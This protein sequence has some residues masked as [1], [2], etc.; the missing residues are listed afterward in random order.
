MIYNQRRRSTVSVSVTYVNKMEI[1]AYFIIV[2]TTITF[3]SVNAQTAT[4][5]SL[6]LTPNTGMAMNYWWGLVLPN[7]CTGPGSPGI[8]VKSDAYSSRR[9]DK[10]ICRYW[11]LFKYQQ[12]VNFIAL[13]SNMM[14]KARLATVSKMSSCTVSEL[15]QFQTVS[16]DLENIWF[17]RPT[18]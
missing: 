11:P 7:S 12:T 3:V 4:C 14:G 8:L 16:T 18:N 9:T 1:L 17:H 15:F 6:G 5:S 2:L 13:T 10:T